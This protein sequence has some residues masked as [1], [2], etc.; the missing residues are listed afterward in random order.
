MGTIEVH[1][2]TP[3]QLDMLKVAV[4]NPFSPRLEAHLRSMYK[5]EVPPDVDELIEAWAQLEA[6]FD[7]LEVE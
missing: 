2:I 6:L 4:M 1:N 7:P 5:P 3:L